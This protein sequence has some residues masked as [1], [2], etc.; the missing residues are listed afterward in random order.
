MGWRNSGMWPVSKGVVYKRAGFDL[1]EARA[2]LDLTQ[3]KV[4]NTE[5]EFHSLLHQMIS[6]PPETATQLREFLIGCYDQKCRAADLLQERL[7]NQYN[8][9]VSSTMRDLYGDDAEIAKRR[10]EDD[11]AARTACRRKRHCSTARI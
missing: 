5:E 3:L 6:S 7:S 2:A 9:Q 1:P 10:A 11:P 4:P 8:L